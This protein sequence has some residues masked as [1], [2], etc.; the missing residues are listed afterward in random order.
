MPV[1][2]GTA[3]AGDGASSR[4]VRTDFIKVSFGLTVGLDIT[5]P[6]SG[7]LFTRTEVT[8]GLKQNDADATDLAGRVQQA[9]ATAKVANGTPFGVVVQI[10][11]APDCDRAQ[12]RHFLPA[13][14]PLDSVVMNL[15]PRWT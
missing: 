9:V 4:I 8:D 7:V 11:L 14:A 6:V 2:A 1:A 12:R 10:V 15:P 3:T 5:V 13:G